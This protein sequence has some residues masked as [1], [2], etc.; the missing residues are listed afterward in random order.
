MYSRISDFGFFAN[1]IWLE[2][3]VEFEKLRPL[4]YLFLFTQY[5]CTNL[6]INVMRKKIK[7]GIKYIT[8]LISNYYPIC[9]FE[10]KYFPRRFEFVTVQADIWKP[11]H[12]VR[13][14]LPQTQWRIRFF[15]TR[16]DFYL[17]ISIHC[18]HYLKTF[19]VFIFWTAQVTTIDVIKVAKRS[20]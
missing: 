9:L 17:Y 10:A 4:H 16:L 12:N 19:V 8:T 18:W 7:V 14:R 2:G 6:L 1:G 20:R 15:A 11:A 13:A 5:V 3:Y